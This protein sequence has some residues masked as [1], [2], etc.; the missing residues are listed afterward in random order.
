MCLCLFE[1]LWTYYLFTLL[2]YDYF[3]RFSFWRR[4]KTT[5]RTVQ[6]E[7]FKKNLEGAKRFVNA[8]INAYTTR[9]AKNDPTFNIHDR[10]DIFIPL[11]ETVGQH[12]QEIAV[13]RSNSI[14][15]LTNS[16]YIKIEWGHSLKQYQKRFLFN[17]IVE[18]EL[19]SHFLSLLSYVYIIYCYY[20]ENI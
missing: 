14:S 13:L 12:W 18:W 15:Y 4:H 5:K 6:S 7:P 16:W 2:T 11:F 9:F 17:W 8:M 20:K 3:V 10:N 19:F 1:F